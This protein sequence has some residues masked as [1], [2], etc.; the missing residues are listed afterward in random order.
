MIYAFISIF[1]Q[2]LNFFPTPTDVM[3]YLHPGHEFINIA[4]KN[5]NILALFYKDVINMAIKLM[6]RQSVS[7]SDYQ[8]ICSGVWHCVM[9]ILNS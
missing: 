5:V 3:P 4:L 1:E 2:K 9:S 6:L 7:Q 8:N